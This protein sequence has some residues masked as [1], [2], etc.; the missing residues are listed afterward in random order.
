MTAWFWDLW[1]EWLE[2]YYG[3]YGGLKNESYLDR[4]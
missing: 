2:F 4:L 3:T 1:D